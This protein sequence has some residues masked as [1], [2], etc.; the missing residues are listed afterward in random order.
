MLNNT[1][2]FRQKTTKREQSDGKIM[3]ENQINF[4]I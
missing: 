4:K 1:M 2:N 3:S